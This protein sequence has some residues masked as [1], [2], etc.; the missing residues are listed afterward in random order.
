[1]DY[2]AATMAQ[3]L[4]PNQMFASTT[5][6]PMTQ[7]G[8]S[9]MPPGAYAP[10]FQ[11]YIDPTQQ[12]Q[13]VSQSYPIPNYQPV[14][15]QIPTHTMYPTSYP[16]LTPTNPGNDWQVV[17]NKK[18]QRSP[19]E[20][21]TSKKTSR[22]TKIK[23]YWLSS[24]QTSNRFNTLREE[25]EADKETPE[26]ETKKEPKPPPIFVS[27]VENI[28]PLIALLNEIAPEK[29]NLKAFN[30]DQVKIQVEDGKSYTTV[31]KALNEKN[32]EYHTYKSK[33]TRTYR[34]VLKN[35][36]SSTDIQEIKNCIEDLGHEVTN[37]WN[38]KQRS[39]NK[40]LP[41]FFIDLKQNDN[42]KDIYKT[43][44]L[45]HTSVTFEAPRTKR[46][47]PQCTRC[48]RFGHTKNF[49]HKNPR[50]V[51]CTSN[52]HTKD[53]PRKTKDEEVK[54]VN[55]NEKHPANYR[56][57]IVHKQLL[58]KLYPK[59]RQKNEQQQN[60][61]RYLQPGVTYSQ[62]MQQ[63]APQINHQISPM[64][65]AQQNNDLA[66]IKIMMKDLIS[67]MGTMMNLISALVN[68]IK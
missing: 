54:C 53:C 20:D 10:Q 61:P 34:V 29:Y 65:S 24:T 3:S 23:D 45:M 5:M 66:E 62:S 35:I 52:H 46:E 41:M 59:L 42:N 68:K 64:I 22:Q 57:C 28:N 7:A 17:V 18:R 47:I 51:K 9:G 36:H 27:G 49:C 67:Q 48:Q 26:E 12:S 63:K 16:P 11:T 60:V 50:C 13:I 37:V 44:Y 58:E 30:T 39:T 33:E 19:E 38:I 2:N 14:N 21:N 4:Q 8:H 6:I 1:M 43:K 15:I 55:C 32:T 25:I 56:G 31:T 40:P